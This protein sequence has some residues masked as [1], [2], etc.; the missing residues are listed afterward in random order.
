[1]KYLKPCN[2]KTILFSVS[3]FI[4]L[5][6]FAQ[7]IDCCINPEWIVPSGQG[8]CFALYDPVVGCNGITY[9]NSCEAEQSGITSYIN[10]SGVS[11]SLDWDCEEIDLGCT[12]QYGFHENGA[13]W[14]PTPCE[15]FSCFDRYIVEAI[16]DCAQWMGMPCDGEW[17][18]NEGDC[19][20][21]CISMSEI[22]SCSGIPILLNNGWNMIGFS[23]EENKNAVLAFSAI[24]DKIVIAKD[25][26]GNAYLPSF[27]F[28]GIGDLERG[29]GYLIKVSEEI[30]NYNLC[31]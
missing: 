19:C 9:S 23:C 29:Y 2:M 24:E 26:Q 21:E 6:T 5:T 13:N 25:A 10:Q 7:T 17:V 27:G 31:E 3:F 4:S 14:S 20:A 15:L 28:N 12:D 11:T 16:I 1:M 30:V 18:L 8:M 22:A